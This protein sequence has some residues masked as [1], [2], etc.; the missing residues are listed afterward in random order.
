MFVI[1]PFCKL[2]IIPRSWHRYTVPSGITVIQWV[3]DFSERVK[4]LQSVSKKVAAGSSKVL[5]VSVA[6]DEGKHCDLQA[7]HSVRNEKCF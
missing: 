2:G 4:Q 5:K 7:K 1:C 6:T 3:T